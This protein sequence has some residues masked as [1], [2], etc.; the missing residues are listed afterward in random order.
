MA[1]GLMRW[2]GSVIRRG[3][4]FWRWTSSPSAL[5]AWM[6]THRP[7]RFGQVAHVLACK[8]WLRFCLTDRVAADSPAIFG[9]L[10]LS[11]KLPR[12]RDPDAIAGRISKAA[13]SPTGLFTDTSVAGGLHDVTASARGF[14]P[15]PS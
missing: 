12:V 4:V 14:R 10:D 1:M 7:T 3:R 13:A 11:G 9:L 5:L 8:D 6:Q 15:V 2:I